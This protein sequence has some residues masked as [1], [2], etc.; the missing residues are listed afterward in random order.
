MRKT[1]KILSEEKCGIGHAMYMVGGKWKLIIL[2]YLLLK[3]RKFNELYSLLKSVTET[4][5]NN[6]L[7]ELIE[8][9][10]IEKV[11]LS[12]NPPRTIYK[13]TNKGHSLGTILINLRKFGQRE[14]E[15]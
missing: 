14:L 1:Y 5:L 15:K 10:L 3:E 11:Y 13:L 12:N 7:K 6:N 8:D 9:G 4:T 2:Y